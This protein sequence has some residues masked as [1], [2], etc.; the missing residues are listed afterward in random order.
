MDQSAQK[1]LGKVLNTMNGSASVSAN[2]E[3]TSEKEEEQAGTRT[4]NVQREKV[5]LYR[6]AGE[7]RTGRRDKV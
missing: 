3:I 2:N 7:T 4:V 6:E 5:I 1:K